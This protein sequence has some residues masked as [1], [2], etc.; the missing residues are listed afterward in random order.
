MYC[1]VLRTVRVYID[2]LEASGS[3]YQICTIEY[4]R[5][6]EIHTN[7]PHLPHLSLNLLLAENKGI[8]VANH[9]L[10]LVILKPDLS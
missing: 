4:R 6:P 1:T 2:S 10:V 5:L 9:S 8:N 7:D 3:C